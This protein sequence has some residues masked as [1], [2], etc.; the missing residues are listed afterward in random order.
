MPF[1][2]RRDDA[3]FGDLLTE[4]ASGLTTSAGL[5]AELLGR[6]AGELPEL[7]P[8]LRAADQA[9]DVRANAVL[10]A[11]SAAMATPFDRADV[12]RLTWAVQTAV[13]RTTAAGEDVVELEPENLPPAVTELVQ[14]LA[15]A[16]EVAE[17]AVR[18]V[19]RADALTDAAVELHRLARQ[20]RGAQRRLLVEACGDEGPDPAGLARR[21][22]VASSFR[23]VV[24]AYEQLG[25]VLQAVAVAES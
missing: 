16:A 17:D 23:S 24:E 25:H 3:R 9:A 8:E 19:P 15:R 11:L 21:V 18:H 4:L 20:A 12:H 6:P 7:L 14:V 2:L 10:R 5:L 22:A 1:R 13:Q